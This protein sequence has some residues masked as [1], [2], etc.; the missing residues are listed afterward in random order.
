MIVAWARIAEDL[1]PSAV[2]C[3][4]PSWTQF[5]ALL[6]QSLASTGL[7]LRRPDSNDLKAGRTRRTG[8]ARRPGVCWVRK[9][10]KD[11]N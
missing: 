6:L 10:L 2:R 11:V 4:V 1:D 7:A 3:S 8:K 5:R 9:D